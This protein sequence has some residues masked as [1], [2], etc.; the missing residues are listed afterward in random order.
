MNSPATAN[1][2]AEALP[3][4]R[5][6]T[7]TQ[8]LRH[9]SVPYLLVAPVLVA[10][11]AVLGYPLYQLIELSFQRYG[12]FELIRH[13]G[14]WIGLHNYGSVLHDQVF[15]HTLVRTVVF[16]GVNVTLTI[17]LGTAIA[18]LLVRV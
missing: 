18:L 1:A 12:L 16:A 15:W 2:A 11:G 17:V 5:H 4:R 7:R 6:I 14:V 8:R 13:S 3:R 10:V 9:G